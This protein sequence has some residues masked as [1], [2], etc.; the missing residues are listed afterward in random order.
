MIELL[1]FIGGLLTYRVALKI[2][3]TGEPGST[4]DKFLR[5]VLGG[6]GPGAVPK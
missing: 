5:G 3:S 1:M 4:R 6:G 2:C